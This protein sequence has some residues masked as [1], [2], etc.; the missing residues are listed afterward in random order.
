MLII[1]IGPATLEETGFRLVHF[2]SGDHK[3]LVIGTY[4]LCA[5]LSAVFIF[6][7]AAFLLNPFLCEEGKMRFEAVIFDLDGND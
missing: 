4:T 2:L 3:Y 1:G 6:Q 5:L 7:I